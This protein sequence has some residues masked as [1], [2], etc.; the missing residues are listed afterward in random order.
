[1]RHQALTKQT[2]HSGD[3]GEKNKAGNLFITIQFSVLYGVYGCLH[4]SGK[5]QGL[6]LAMCPLGLDAFF[7]WS[8]QFG[9]QQLIFYWPAGPVFFLFFLRLPF[10]FEKCYAGGS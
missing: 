5:E 4:V 6:T 2:A 7:R 8:G 3:D 9:P 1:M 10:I